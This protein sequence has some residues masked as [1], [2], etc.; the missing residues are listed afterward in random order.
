M[1]MRDEGREHQLETVSG[2][3]SRQGEQRTSPAQG[4]AR[5]NRQAGMNRLPRRRMLC[6]LDCLLL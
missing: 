4:I 2:H 5:N 3:L 6:L 1:R